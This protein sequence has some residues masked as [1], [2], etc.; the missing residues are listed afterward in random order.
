MF[1]Q[2]LLLQKSF[3]LFGP[4]GTGKTT[5]LKENFPNAVNVDLLDS[6]LCTDLL[7][8]PE[9]LRDLV[10]KGGTRTVMTDEVQRVPELLN[11]THRLIEPEGTRFILTGSSARTRRRRGSPAKRGR[12]KRIEYWQKV[13]TRGFL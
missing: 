12:D 4:R 9:R 6:A 7:A 11:E 2:T 8:H 3:F 10:P 5:W 1:R 13:L